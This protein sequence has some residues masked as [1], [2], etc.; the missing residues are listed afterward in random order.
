MLF[1]DQWLTDKSI[2][3]CMEALIG[4]YLTA[5]GIEATQ[6][7]LCH[8]GLTGNTAGETFFRQ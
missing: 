4:A 3:D 1:T 2:A 5:S 6:L 8:M 7:F